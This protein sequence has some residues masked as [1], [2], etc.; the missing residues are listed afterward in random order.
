[1]MKRFEEG[2]LYC[3]KC[4][5]ETNAVVNIIK[6]TGFGFVLVLVAL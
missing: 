1:M 6:R 2:C 4:D 3:A 5:G